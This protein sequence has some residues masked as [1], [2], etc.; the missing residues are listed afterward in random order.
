MFPSFQVKTGKTNPPVAGCIS[1]LDKKA[2]L[3]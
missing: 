1:G 2:A 3:G